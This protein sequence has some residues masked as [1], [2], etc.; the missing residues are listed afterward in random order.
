MRRS[1]LLVGSAFL[2]LVGP[3]ASALAGGNWL[4]FRKDPQAGSG[5]GGT[6]GTWAVVHVGQAIVAHTG[7]YVPN[8]RRM[9]R[10]AGRTVYAWLTPSRTH[11]GGPDLPVG[12]IR[13]AP[14]RVDVSGDGATVR[15]RFVVPEVPSGEYEVLICDDP[16][17]EP[18]FGYYVQGWIT[19]MQTPREA[20]LFVL[21]DERGWR[22][23][24]AKRHL[25][26][27]QR[28]QLALQAE[29]DDALLGVRMT[30]RTADAQIAALRAELV[31]AIDRDSAPEPRATAWPLVLAWT[32]AF[33]ASAVTLWAV[34]SRRRAAWLFDVPDT[35]PEDLELESVR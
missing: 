23:R 21:A 2:F 11:F 17:T 32:V 29:L 34:S 27:A 4:D 13:L 24:E 12:A 7:I 16:C 10:L 1:L 8:D 28:E 6:I 22:L 30:E 33:A 5:Q 25:R 9:D 35:V 14:F 15:A 26:R 3:A 19:V 31:R 20:R 18:G